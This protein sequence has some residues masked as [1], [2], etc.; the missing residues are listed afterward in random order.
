M[1]N[2][3]LQVNHFSKYKLDA[4]DDSDDENGQDVGGVKKIKTQVCG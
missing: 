3:V 4:D 2:V 1:I